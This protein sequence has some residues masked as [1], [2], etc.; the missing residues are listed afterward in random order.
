MRR[1][2][3][4]STEPAVVADAAA[5]SPGR[6]MNPEAGNRILVAAVDLLAERGWEGLS[7]DALAAR[8]R[9]GKATIYRRWSGKEA[10]VIA[11]LERFVDDFR[12]I[13]S[14]SLRGDLIV[15]LTD[16]SAK[17]HSPEGKL[18]AALGSAME[19]SSN[20]A[21]AVR[22]NFLEPKRENV[23]QILRR[24]RDRGELAVDA[25]LDLIHDLLAGP[26]L[27][28]RLITGQRL[29][30]KLVAGVVDAVVRGFAPSESSKL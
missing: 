11:A 2:T 4:T 21:A 8:A 27:Y 10:V 23:K 16:A 28:R 26:L 3:E 6:P 17:Y 12:H 29:D 18:L 14:G 20:L 19:Q 9:V 30:K 1:T 24:A 7:M 25:D 5:R 13:D 22:R 15:L